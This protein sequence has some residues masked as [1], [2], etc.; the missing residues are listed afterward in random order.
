MAAGRVIVVGYLSIDRIATA[1]AQA[2]TVPGGAAL[3]CAL[4]AHSAGALVSLVAS[5]GADWPQAW[6]DALAARGIDVSGVLRRP[7]PTRRAVVHYT[8]DWRRHS[9]HHGEVS[10]WE[11]TDALV[12]PEPPR[13]T[14]ADTIVA[15]PMRAARLRELLD[16][17]G[18]ARV[19]ADTSEAFARH[20]PAALRA[21]LSA[22]SVF[23][24]SRE[25]TCLLSPGAD[26]G[27]ALASLGTV[28]VEKRG[29]DG[30][31]VYRSSK[32]PPLLV[33]A[34]TVAMV[35][36]TGAGDAT[37]GALAAA[38]ARGED[39]VTAARSAVL[40]GARCVTGPGPSALGFAWDQIP[41]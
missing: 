4:G 29:A 5:A 41:I 19:V 7:G 24:P 20:E 17:F 1:S 28:V 8:A 30:L 18:G 6:T 31:A 12:P 36:P 39:V 10:W 26:P 22:I 11:R 35:E 21:L 32:T 23:A 37:V 25:E 27:R 3:Y 14:A 34:P 40:V 9:L 15:C 16:R 2:E 38:L 33:T 13:A